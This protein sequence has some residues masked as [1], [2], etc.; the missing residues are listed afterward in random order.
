M[1]CPKT[2]IARWMF[3]SGVDGFRDSV[4]RR[5]DRCRKREEVK[6]ESVDAGNGRKTD[7]RKVAG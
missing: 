7:G 3:R 4:G 1:I 2:S 5:D 6:V